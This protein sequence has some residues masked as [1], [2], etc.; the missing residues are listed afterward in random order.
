MFFFSDILL[1]ALIMK[2]LWEAYTS[3]TLPRELFMIGTFALPLLWGMGGKVAGRIMREGVAIAGLLIFLNSLS[4]NG[5]KGFYIAFICMGVL[6]YM[7]G[8]LARRSL[9]YIVFAIGV[10]AIVV[11]LLMARA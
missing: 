4:A 3:K 6:L 10:A 1:M 9:R 5:F 7:F 2:L 11:Y 8:R